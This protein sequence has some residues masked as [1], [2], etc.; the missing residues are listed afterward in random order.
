MRMSSTHL[1]N[2]TIIIALQM[3][4]A[5]G[6]ELD[7][8]EASSR[9]EHLYAS[10]E[11]K[12]EQLKK[13]RSIKT[14]HDREMQRINEQSA[15]LESMETLLLKEQQQLMALKKEIE[16]LE[17]LL[18]T[19]KA[20]NQFNAKVDRFNDALD[21]LT[22]QEDAYEQ[23]RKTLQASIN[24]TQNTSFNREMSLYADDVL[25]DGVSTEKQA[26]SEVESWIMGNC[27]FK[28]MEG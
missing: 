28:G 20:V 2:L 19:Q 5:Y 23:L 27:M 7:C 10:L 21:V 12:N 9:Y 18:I 16:L 3:P 22:Q 15:Q 8:D 25:T 17:N 13:Y 6:K 14:E 11:K 26:L 1:I 4:L 24:N